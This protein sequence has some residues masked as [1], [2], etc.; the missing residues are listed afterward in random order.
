MNGGIPVTSALGREP[1]PLMTN[2]PHWLN[3]RLM[4]KRL[5]HAAESNPN[6]ASSAVEKFSHESFVTAQLVRG[7]FVGRLGEFAERVG[8]DAIS[9][10]RGVL[11][12]H[13]RN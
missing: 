3:A 1:A 11:V 2:R 4:P 6:F 13:R 12:A 7:R 9:V 10:L 8:N 5:R